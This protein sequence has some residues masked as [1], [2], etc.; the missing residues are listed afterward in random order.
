M[1][2]SSTA[3]CLDG[4]SSAYYVSRT[5]DSSKVLIYIQGGGWCYGLNE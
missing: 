4:T 5:G 1:L 2:N 3:L